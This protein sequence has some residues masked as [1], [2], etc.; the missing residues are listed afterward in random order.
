MDQI[1]NYCSKESTLYSRIQ[2][3]QVS[4]ASL[5]ATF[6][7]LYTSKT[8]DLTIDVTYQVENLPSF[9]FFGLTSQ[10]N[11][12]T[13]SLSVKVP[14]NLYSGA[15]ICFQC[16]LNASSSDFTF[17][18]QAQQVS[19]LVLQPQSVMSIYQSLIQFRLNGSVGGLIYKLKTRII[20]ENCN[21]SGF[22]GQ[23]LASGSIACYV[24]IQVEFSVN[25]VRLCT[26]INQKA[27]TGENLVKVTGI[28]IY[29]C[30]ICQNKVYAYGICVQSLNNSEVIS[31][32]LVCKNSFVFDGNKCSCPADFIL[33]GSICV[34]IL[35][36]VNNFITVQQDFNLKAANNISV[37]NS[38][39]QTLNAKNDGLQ[40]NI[41][42][43]KQN[44]TQL[45]V[46]ITNFQSNQSKLIEDVKI[47]KL[48][49]QQMQLLINDLIN[50]INCSGHAFI[51]GQCILQGCPISGQQLLNGTCQCPEDQQLVNGQCQSVQ[52]IIGQNSSF[53][54]NT[55]VFINVFDI[56]TI[57]N[58]ILSSDEFSSGYVFG[59]STNIQNAFIDV[60]D[61]VYSSVK[62]LFQGQTIYKNIKVQIGTQSITSGSIIISTGSLIVNYM[63]IISRVGSQITV[64]G[65]LNI[66]MEQ[67]TRSNITNLLVNMSFAS[68]YS[69]ISLINQI[70]GSTNVTWYQVY[71]F[72]QSTSTVSLVGLSANTAKVSIN[73]VSFKPSVFNVGNCSSYLISS[74]DQSQVSINNIAIILGNN[75][76]SQVLGSLQS[77]SSI[78]Y[79]FGGIITNVL[80][81]S[82]VF[83]NNI[84]LDGY[85]QFNT[86]FVNNSGVLVGFVQLNTSIVDIMNVCMNQKVKSPSQFTNYGLCGYNNG[87]LSLQLSSVTFYI[88]G[89]S[90]K[91]F[92]LVGYQSSDSPHADAINLRISVKTG[93][94]SSSGDTVGALFGGQNARNCSVQNSIIVD[95]NISSK[96]RVGGYIGFSK[97][98]KLSIN[99]TIQNSSIS[100]SNITGYTST[101]GFIGSSDSYSSSYNMTILNST[102]QTSNINGINGT[103]GYIG[104]SD[105]NPSSFYSIR[106][107]NSSIQT[108]NVSGTNCT[109]GLIGYSISRNASTF[110]IQSFKFSSIRIT[111][112][113][114]Y[115]IVL[116]FDDMTSNYATK[117]QFLDSISSG[118]FLNGA[119]MANCAAIQN[120]FALVGC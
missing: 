43:L 116:G 90:L 120:A 98:Q 39:I 93:V 6:N 46:I 55:S 113:Y 117:F 119:Q 92:G 63:N 53:Q 10:I 64:S 85:Y 17:I 37:L 61:G 67:S 12:S 68:T 29:T 47:L 28:I 42:A 69:Q 45:D 91:W 5:G 32:K 81:G 22:V 38:T 3:G 105:P 26:N 112:Q 54:C 23:S 94:D 52:I 56:Q 51:N 104:Y 74:V 101:G 106:I 30:D 97:D 114:N 34:N 78:F 40:S 100:L 118:N 76:N 71:G 111:A 4:H 41:S 62:P 14:Q 13:S 58:Q 8:Q 79:Q 33:N 11:I 27:E 49:N 95:S 89:T 19:G 50:Q 102:V 108:S 66:L 80:S 110:Y 88:Q 73:Q 83:I 2:T 103:G 25:N 20:T 21:I 36:S 84:L 115:R 109:G 31:M 75:T 107:Q 82:T 24:E 72:Y 7:S 87:D 59:V 15:L 44:L 57:T 86:S 35:N 60:I 16:D 1:L 48:Q 9:A 65:K 70:G 99:T 18:A 77:T 96:Y